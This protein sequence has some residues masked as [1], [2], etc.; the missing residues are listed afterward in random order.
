MRKKLLFSLKTASVCV[1]FILFGLELGPR[2]ATSSSANRK[3]AE[4]IGVSEWAN[5]TSQCVTYRK[6]SIVD[7]LK[8]DDMEKNDIFPDMNY[9]YHQLRNMVVFFA[10]RCIGMREE[11]IAKLHKN[12]RFIQCTPSRWA[13]DL[14]TDAKLLRHRQENWRRS[15]YKSSFYNLSTLLHNVFI[16]TAN[17]SLAFDDIGLPITHTACVCS[18]LKMTNNT[19]NTDKRTFKRRPNDV[20]AKRSDPVII[21]HKKVRDL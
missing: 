3:R 13:I 8:R 17:E 21:V 4:S 7:H 16:F 18:A 20:E 11:I 19:E 5:G 15:I 12:L 10:V 9:N 6:W 2:T 1:G 14:H